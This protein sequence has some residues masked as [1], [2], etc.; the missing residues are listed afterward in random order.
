[1]DTENKKKLSKK[2]HDSVKDRSYPN[3]DLSKDELIEEVRVHQIELEL[4]NEELQEFQEK[5][6]NSQRK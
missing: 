4:K 3:H 1:M 2:A 5:L 6:A